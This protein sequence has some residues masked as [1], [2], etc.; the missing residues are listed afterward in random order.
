MY[1]HKILDLVD[2]YGLI[3][4]IKLERTHILLVVILTQCNAILLRI[5]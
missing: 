4:M 5:E 1:K 2:F 3:Q